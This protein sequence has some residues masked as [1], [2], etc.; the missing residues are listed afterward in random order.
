[1]KASED[2]PWLITEPANRLTMRSSYN[3][4][5]SVGFR[6]GLAKPAMHREENGSRNLAYVARVSGECPFDPSGGK[7]LSSILASNLDDSKEPPQLAAS[8][9]T[10]SDGTLI[11]RV[12]QTRHEVSP[13]YTSLPTYASTWV[14][15]VLSGNSSNIR[16]IVRAILFAVYCGFSKSMTE[17]SKALRLVFS[18]LLSSYRLL[19][20]RQNAVHCSYCACEATSSEIKAWAHVQ[21][22]NSSLDERNLDLRVK[23]A[24]EAEAKACCLGS[25]EAGIVELR[26]KLEA[27]KRFFSLVNVY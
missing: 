3:A 13:P 1:M 26:Q 9:L 4:L 27:S 5:H 25:S 10:T 24:I 21:S 6:H 20:D 7:K 8:G 2:D 19:N 17:S 14:K 11:T 15:R 23:V 18:C 16:K 12:G 22:L